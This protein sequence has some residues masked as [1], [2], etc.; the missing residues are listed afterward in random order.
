MQNGTPFAF[1]DLARYESPRVA[2]RFPVELLLSYLQNF[3]IE[4]F[5]ASFYSGPG[6]ILEVARPKPAT[7]KEYATFADARAG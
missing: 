4:L 3:D 7:M 5:D 1:E 2:D 6:V